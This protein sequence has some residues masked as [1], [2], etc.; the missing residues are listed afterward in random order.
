MTYTLTLTEQ[1]LQI[2]AAGL[3]ELPMKI[4]APMVQEIQK[5]VSEQA[6]KPSAEPIQFSD[7]AE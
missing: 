7:A 3:G 6:K 5:Q 1:H 4:A 2:I